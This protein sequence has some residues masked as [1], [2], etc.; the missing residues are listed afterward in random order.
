MD[1]RDI[2]QLDYQI[3]RINKLGKSN[4]HNRVLRRSIIMTVSAGKTVQTCS[5]LVILIVVLTCL[6]PFVSTQEM[7]F[8]DV[9]KRGIVKDKVIETANMYADVVQ[10]DVKGKVKDTFI[11]EI[12]NVIIPKG[13]MT[14]QEIMGEL[15][16]GIVT[17]GAGPE[18]LILKE[19]LISENR[20]KAV[21]KG[22]EQSIYILANLIERSTP[23][24]NE[25]SKLL[26]QSMGQSTDYLA[27]AI[28]EIGRKL[29]D[30][31]GLE[32]R[33]HQRLM[34]VIPDR[35]PLLY[36]P[37]WAKLQQLRDGPW[38]F[39]WAEPRSPHGVREYHFKLNNPNTREVMLETTLKKTIIVIPKSNRTFSGRK[40]MRW[41]WSVEAIGGDNAKGLDSLRGFYVRELEK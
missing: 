26:V 10:F 27:D 3:D 20:R 33:R 30:I 11:T 15:I 4:I 31:V 39:M 36:P 23:A 24:L 21:M 19:I 13:E 1:A 8:K 6:S 35:P 7:V 2:C 29:R 9:K 14:P 17:I 12:I 41:A 28:V 34:T 5:G 37:A 32:R 38:V 16:Y 25:G 18:Y 22:I 40:Q